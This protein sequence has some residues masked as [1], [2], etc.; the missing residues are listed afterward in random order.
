MLDKQLRAAKIQEEENSIR[1]RE[2]IKIL[3]DI[4]KTL[5]GQELA[6]RGS[7]GSDGNF[8]A[9]AQLVARHNS[10][11]KSWMSDETMKPYLVRYL[12][13]ASQNEFISLLADDVKSGIAQDVNSAGMYSVMADTSPDT[14]NTDRLVVAVRYVDGTNSPK[15]RVLEVKEAIDKTGQGQ[16]KEILDSLN[17]RLSNESEL[18]Y[19]SYD[20]TAS[21]SGNFKGAQQ[22]LQDMV[23][24]SIPYIPCQSHRYLKC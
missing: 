6:F 5:A 2:A 14:S 11:L 24:R 8:I 3:L 12:S 19:Q 10:H 15:E 16:A 4:S 20:Y 22:C 13:L 1:N 9:I 17:S 7:D 18:V 21:M 23:G